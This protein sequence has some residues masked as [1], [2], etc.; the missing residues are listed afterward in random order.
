MLYGLARDSWSLAP[1]KL[2][3][4]DGNRIHGGCASLLPTVSEID[5]NGQMAMTL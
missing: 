4:V 5:L 2:Q 3:E 1:A